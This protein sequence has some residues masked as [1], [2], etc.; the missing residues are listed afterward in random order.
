MCLIGG[1][2][3]M[4][5]WGVLIGWVSRVQMPL[6]GGYFEFTL[7][8]CNLAFLPAFIGGLIWWISRVC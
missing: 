5:S 2:N 1:V 8:G 4:G 7:E 6:K 3:E